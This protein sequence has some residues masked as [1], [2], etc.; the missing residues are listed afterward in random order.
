MGGVLMRCSQLHSLTR[1]I[2]SGFLITAMAFVGIEL[3]L[4]ADKSHERLVKFFGV[5]YH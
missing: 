2:D 4:D 1:L 5:D 3:D